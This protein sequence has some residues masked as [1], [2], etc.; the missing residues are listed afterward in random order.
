MQWQITVDQQGSGDIVL[1]LPTADALKCEVI[2]EH[3]DTSATDA[4]R[5]LRWTYDFSLL[6]SGRVVLPPV[7]AYL[8]TPEGLQDSSSTSALL[9][10]F[11]LVPAD[12]SQPHRDISGIHVVARD[13]PWIWIAATAATVLAMAY[14][15]RRYKKRRN[16]TATP[17]TAPALSAAEIALRHLAEL[18]SRQ[19]W[20]QGRTK[21]YYSELAII[22]RRFV[23]SRYGIA[24]L[25]STTDEIVL[26]MQ[27]LV[28]SQESLPILKDMLAMA[29][30][31]KFAKFAPREEEHTE[32]LRK[33]TSYVRTSE[34]A[35]AREEMR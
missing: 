32:I 7:T 34:S 19:L 29:D 30:L 13:I 1:Q 28:G 11:S 12:T 35:T 31:V 16:T 4:G 25:E 33:A 18:E 14:Y 20:Q 15:Y 17:A 24:A 2:A 3:T 8:R 10:D 9:V 27:R 6:D 5:T 23:E 26:R 21:E 22:L